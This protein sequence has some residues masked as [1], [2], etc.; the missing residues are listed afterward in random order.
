MRV[1]A[2]T[3][4]RTRERLLR[5]ARRLFEKKGFEQAATRDITRAAGIALGTLF[6]YFPSKEALALAIIDGAWDAAR[7]E[8][9]ESLRGNESLEELLFSHLAIGLRHL[10]PCRPYAVAVFECTLSPLSSGETCR[11]ADQLRL[12]HV[13]TVRRLLAQNHEDAETAEPSF[14]SLHLY[15]TLFLGVLAFWAK[16]ESTNQEDT[17]ALLDQSVRLFVA[18]LLTNAS[19]LEN[20]HDA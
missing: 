12:T 5:C 8:F 10:R 11:E 1:T 9:Q 6:N 7:K 2:Q 20:D 19:K 17:L 13:E 15:W 4:N 14:V 16:D 3:K 18:T